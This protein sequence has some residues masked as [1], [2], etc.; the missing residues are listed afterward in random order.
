M[1]AVK[2]IV[3]SLT[4]IG[5]LALGLMVAGRGTAQAYSDAVTADNTAQITITIRP[6]VNRSVTITTDTVGMLDMGNVSVT[7]GFVSTQTVSPAT[8]TVGGTFG[9][10]DLLLSGNIV[11]G[12]NFDNSSSSLETDNLATWV[13]FTSISS[14]TAPSQNSEYFNGNTQGTNSDLL[15]GGSASPNVAAIRIGAGGTTGGEFENDFTNMNNMVVNSQRHMWTFFRMPSGTST[16]DD[17]KVTLVLT[18]ES[19]L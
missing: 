17:Q 10:T 16:T 3:A 12:W 6:N 9:N 4:G 19:G 8:V 5:M 15:A 11:G 14:A 7:G 1:N 13:S 2:K 18:V